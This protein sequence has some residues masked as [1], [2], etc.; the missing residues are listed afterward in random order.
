MFSFFGVA[1]DKAL[2]A[3]GLSK[4]EIAYRVLP[5]FLMEIITR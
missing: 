2:K 4:E 1:I 3:S 5:H